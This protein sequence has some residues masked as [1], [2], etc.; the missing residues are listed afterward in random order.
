MRTLGALH[1][2]IYPVCC[3]VRVAERD[4]YEPFIFIS[5]LNVGAIP[6]QLRH[7]PFPHPG[8]YAVYVLQRPQTLFQ[9]GS[10]TTSRFYVPKDDQ[11]GV[12]AGRNVRKADAADHG[13]ECHRSRARFTFRNDSTRDFALFLC[14]NI[15]TRRDVT[16]SILITPYSFFGITNQSPDN[17]PV[18]GQKEGPRRESNS[19]ELVLLLHQ[20]KHANLSY[21]AAMAGRV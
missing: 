2:H 5:P 9:A 21:F 4:F 18:L 13:I 10:R 1:H 19:L 8:G 16:L 20:Y 7:G 14:Y 6:E 17:S 15:P 3:L 11:G 12:V